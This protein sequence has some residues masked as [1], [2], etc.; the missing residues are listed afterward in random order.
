MQWKV[1]Q[2]EIAD[3]PTTVLCQPSIKKKRTISERAKTHR[4][5]EVRIA[6]AMLDSKILGYT[7]L[8]LAIGVTMLIHGTGRIFAIP[9]F[10]HEL[11]ALACFPPATQSSQ[12]RQ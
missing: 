5:F 1:S 6:F 12:V 8:R 3:G 4:S 7:T 2:P 9:K 11:T 10:S